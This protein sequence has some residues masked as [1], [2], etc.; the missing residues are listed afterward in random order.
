MVNH[1]H[2]TSTSTSIRTG[3]NDNKKQLPSKSHLN[4]CIPWCQTSTALH[5]KNLNHWL[6][7]CCGTPIVALRNLRALQKPRLCNTFRPRVV[8]KSSHGLAVDEKIILGNII[9]HKETINIKQFQRYHVDLCIAIPM[10]TEARVLLCPSYW[11]ATRKPIRM[12]PENL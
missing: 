8:S 10:S 4:S 12:E 7:A 5:C 6:V 11:K 9:T 3:P 1:H 2:S